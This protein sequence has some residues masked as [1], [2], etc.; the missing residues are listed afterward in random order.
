MTVLRQSRWLLPITVLAALAVLLA[1]GIWQ[2]QRRDEKV[3]QLA[4]LERAITTSPVLLEA[5][6]ARRIII[7]PAGTA[8]ELPARIGELQRI[9]IAGS[10]LPVPPVAVRVTIPATRDSRQPS[11]IGFFVMSPL[12][13]D[14]GG[15]VFINRGF[16]LAGPG[17]KPPPL[18]LPSGPA[19]IIGLARRA[20][21][22]TF[23]GPRDVPEKGE[24]FVRDPS[25]LAVASGLSD[26]LPWFIDEERKDGRDGP[27]GADAAAMVARIPNNHLHYALTWFGLAATLLGVAGAFLWSRRREPS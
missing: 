5:S 14:G 18:S 20:E 3:A 24:F 7:A 17:W 19:E 8:A 16:V 21:L 9:R 25:R 15:V 22:A 26:V 1:L 12:R 13:L 2:L 11:G 6:V 27:T 4:A 10:F 23:F